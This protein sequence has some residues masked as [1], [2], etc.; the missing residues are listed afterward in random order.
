ME[1][2]LK[3]KKKVDTSV[4]C[5]PIGE[6]HREIGY[7]DESEMVSLLNNYFTLTFTLE[8]SG[9]LL[10]PITERIYQEGEEVGWWSWGEFQVGVE[11]VRTIWKTLTH[12][13]R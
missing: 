11:E 1:G 6:Q 10:L 5:G 8:Q 12:I 7:S 3:K 13:P 9:E 4:G 2:R